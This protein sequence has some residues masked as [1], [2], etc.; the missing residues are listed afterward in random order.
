MK[1]RYRIRGIGNLPSSHPSSLFLLPSSKKY[2]STFS[3]FTFKL[4]ELGIR[5][6]AHSTYGFISKCSFKPFSRYLLTSTSPPNLHRDKGE[7]LKRWKSERMQ[8]LYKEQKAS[9]AVHLFLYWNMLSFSFTIIEF[10]LDKAFKWLCSTPLPLKRG[11]RE[12]IT[13]TELT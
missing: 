9:N 4:R 7:R 6:N 3:L 10:S 1:Y 11:E 8:A 2:P 13:Y 12:G 5:N